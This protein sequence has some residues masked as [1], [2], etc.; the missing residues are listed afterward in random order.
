MPVSV[1]RGYLPALSLPLG[2]AGALAAGS[3]AAAPTVCPFRICTGQACPGCGMTRGIAAALR[4]DLPLSVRYHPLA[5][6]VGAQLMVAWIVYLR[7]GANGWPDL[8]RRAVPL[9]WL[10]VVALLITWVLRW[11]LGLLDLVV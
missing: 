5:M 8:L 9:L 1:R 10:N 11:H 4:G 2:T 3:L 7:V 6:V